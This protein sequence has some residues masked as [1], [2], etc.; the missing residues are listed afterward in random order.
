MTFLDLAIPMFPVIVILGIVLTI[1]SKRNRYNRWLNENKTNH[2]YQTINT[3]DT[4][5]KIYKAIGADSFSWDYTNKNY[6]DRPHLLWYH[7]RESTACPADRCFFTPLVSTRHFL[8]DMPWL[9]CIRF[10]RWSKNIWSS[11]NP[12]SEKPQ[13]AK[14]PQT[15]SC[16]MS[17]GNSTPRFNATV[18]R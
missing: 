8:I 11:K 12:Q 13:D 16:R 3:A 14:T 18:S 6:E 15:M 10:R 9:A 1:C 2:E 7:I 4:L 17:K 5:I